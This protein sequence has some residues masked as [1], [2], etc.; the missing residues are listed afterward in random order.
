MEQPPRI[1]IDYV[2][3]RL[4]RVRVH[5]R[6]DGEEAAMLMDGLE[7]HVVDQPYFMLLAVITNITGVTPEGRR[8]A[9]ERLRR[10]PRR[11]IAIVGGGFAQR[12]TAKL[13]L[14]AITVLGHRTKTTGAFF[15]DEARAQ[16]WLEEQAA[17]HAA[18]HAGSD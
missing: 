6:I 17:H 15:E 1:E 10:L 3:E 2:S 18:Q 12:T 5:G 14:T 7:A 11:I 16:A 13:V 8:T 9:A 4:V